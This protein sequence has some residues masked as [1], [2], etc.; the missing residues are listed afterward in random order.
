[1]NFHKSSLMSSVL[2]PE[3]WSII[4]TYA[5]TQEN[6]EKITRSNLIPHLS[7]LDRGVINVMRSMSRT[8][9]TVLHGLRLQTIPSHA[10]QLYFDALHKLDLSIPIHI[11]VIDTTRPKSSSWF[12]NHFLIGP[13]WSNIKTF[14]IDFSVRTEQIMTYLPPTIQSLHIKRSY[15]DYVSPQPILDYNCCYNT[16]TELSITNA[17]GCDLDLIKDCCPNIQILSVHDLNSSMVGHSIVSLVLKLPQLHTLRIQSQYELSEL[18]MNAICR[19]TSRITT[20]ELGDMARISWLKHF[21]FPRDLKHLY[22]NG[23]KQVSL[24]DAYMDLN[25]GNFSYNDY[26]IYF[27][28]SDTRISRESPSEYYLQY[29]PKCLLVHHINPVHA[30]Y[31]PMLNIFIKRELVK[32]FRYLINVIKVDINQKN[33]Q[34]E[35]PLV[36]ACR[37]R[38]WK[39]ARYLISAGAD[40][41]Q[42]CKGGYCALYHSYCDQ[43]TAEM[44]IHAG[45]SLNRMVYVNEKKYGKQHLVPLY[46][47]IWLSNRHQAV[48]WTWLTQIFDFADP[49]YLAF[50]HNTKPRNRNIRF[51]NRAIQK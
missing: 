4:F 23:I 7:L 44:L 6:S 50:K 16:I 26:R 41:E 8:L 43:T 48:N 33:E 22:L 49:S 18:M 5:F 46:Y 37:F 9:R 38:K 28:A 30:L 25:L 3:L 51:H 13:F 15:R 19:G 21:Q 32:A 45:S 47:Q 31:Q 40:L 14:T 24:F 1:M 20:L 12:E 35:T 10:Y 11:N 29:I 2:L 17:T 39:F 34:G 27:W 36:F 42:V